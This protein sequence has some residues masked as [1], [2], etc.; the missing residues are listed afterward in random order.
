MIELDFVWPGS[1][2]PNFRAA[3][4][5]DAAAFALPPPLRRQTYSGARR[6][7]V[8]YEKKAQDYLTNRYGEF[9]VSSPWFQF[10]ANGQRRWCQP[11]GLLFHLPEGR[12]TIVEIKYQHTALAWWQVKFLY[13]PVLRQAFRATLWQLDFCEVVKWYDPA[14]FFP[15]PTA[16]AADVGLRTEKFKV[17]IWKP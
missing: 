2:P 16:L 1:A 6:T 11:D 15:E 7:G 10:Q 5:V 4:L 9:Y 13:A 8:K 17:H 12:I 14:A 3:G